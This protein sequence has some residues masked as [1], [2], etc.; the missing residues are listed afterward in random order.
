MKIKKPKI[1]FLI[2]ETYEK[3]KKINP[4]LKRYSTELKIKGN[5]SS[6]DSVDVVTFFSLLDKEINKNKL[7]NPDFMNENFFFRLDNITIK[8]VIDKIEKENGIK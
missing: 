7:K 5:K 8:N 1:S 4:K 2:K 6:F 3:L